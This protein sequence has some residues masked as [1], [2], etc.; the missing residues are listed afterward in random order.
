VDVEAMMKD[1]RILQG[2]MREI[3]ARIVR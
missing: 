2:Q 3:M 1:F